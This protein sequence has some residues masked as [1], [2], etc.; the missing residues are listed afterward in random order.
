LIALSAFVVAGVSSAGEQPAKP[1]AAG[2]AAAPASFVLFDMAT[3]RAT[4][5]LGSLRQ[6]FGAGEVKAEDIP[7]AEEMV[8]GWVLHPGDP[9]QR[10]Y[11]YLDDAGKHPANLTVT[12]PE[13]RWQRGDGI[14]MG[15]TLAELATRNG[16]PIDFSGFGWDYGGTILDWHGGKLSG[17][18]GITL[19]P[20]DFPGDR[21]P[22]GYPMGDATF[23][24][25]Q[26]L[27]MRYPPK[28]CSFDLAPAAVP[29]KAS[30][31]R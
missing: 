5:T 27:V 11:V 14:H 20:P 21:E 30:A 4:D 23:S 1:T 9:R 24:S 22:K 26:P 16:K 12:D 19:C 29:A 28:V 3:V 25:A 15:I 6:R 31:S 17:T 18:H 2:H 10:V 8:P 7:G 13:S